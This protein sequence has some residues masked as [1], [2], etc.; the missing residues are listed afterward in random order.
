MYRCVAYVTCSFL[1]ISFLPF[2]NK[3]PLLGSLTA[4]ECALDGYHKLSQMAEDIFGSHMF[5]SGKQKQKENK[6]GDEIAF[7]NS[8]IIQVKRKKSTTMEEVWI[9]G[10]NR[11]FSLSRNKK[12]NQK[13]SSAKS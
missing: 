4:L 5:C 11:S 3:D 2:I 8:L 10:L 9:P 6:T 12:I 7:S 1:L 13:L